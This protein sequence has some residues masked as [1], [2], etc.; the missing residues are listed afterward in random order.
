MSFW[1]RETWDRPSENPTEGETPSVIDLQDRL[2]ARLNPLPPEQRPKDLAMLLAAV[3]T[4]STTTRLRVAVALGRQHALG[5]TDRRRL[6]LAQRRYRDL[7]ADLVGEPDPRTVPEETN[8]GAE[9]EESW[10]H[11]L[12]RCYGLP[13]A[14]FAVVILLAK[15]L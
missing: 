9:L 4:R 6:A 5:K 12:A 10:A 8:D 15:L 13:F 11:L 2:E 7:P 3:R 14:G 1:N